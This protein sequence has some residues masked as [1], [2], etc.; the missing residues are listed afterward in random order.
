MN[1]LELTRIAVFLEKQAAVLP[2]P[3]ATK[4]AEGAFEAWCDV[5]HIFP[6]GDE[7]REM[8]I[9]MAADQAVRMVRR[10]QWE[11]RNRKEE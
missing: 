10:V 2:E 6:E 7:G 9:Q 11:P 4:A 5:A 3:G 8:A 1:V